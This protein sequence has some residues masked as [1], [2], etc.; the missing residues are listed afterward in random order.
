MIK[1]VSYKWFFGLLLAI[2]L[3]AAHAARADDAPAPKVIFDCNFANGD[4]DKYGWKDQGDLWTIY[5][6][7]S[8]KPDLKSSP[9]PVAKFGKT[10]DGFKGPE[11]LTKKFTPLVKPDSLTL[12]FDGGWG[13][14]APGQSSDDLNVML[15]DDDGNGY[16]F[17]AHRVKD[18]WAAQWGV[19]TKYVIPASLT[20]SPDVIDN[21]QASIMDNG[22]LKTYT[23]KRDKF[24]A[25]QF[26][27]SDWPAPFSFS[28]PSVTTSTFSQVVLVGTG[29][30]DD[31][32][33]NKIHLEAI[34]PDDANAIPKL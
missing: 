18:K 9:G 27:R 28:E 22:G 21:T 14:G 13:W 32:C 2:G 16:I 29:N 15:L 23:I 30:F 1:H 25:W 3:I 8:G 12:S 7:S 34:S 33:Y 4:F 19:V 24:G 10:P 20:W 31:N 5:D 11:L 17:H 26:S 6:Y